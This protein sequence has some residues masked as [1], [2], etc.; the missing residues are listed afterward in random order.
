[1]SIINKAIDAAQLNGEKVFTKSRLSFIRAVAIW[2]L[3]AVFYFYD[4]L[5]QVSPSAMKPEL[6]LA[7]TSHAEQF[8]SLSAYCLYAYGLM[9]IPAGLLLDRFGPKRIIT[10]ACALCA[11]GS[12]IFGLSQTLWMAKL[13]RVCIGAGASFALLCCLKVISLWFPRARYA[14]M[15]GCTVT[16]GYLGGAFGLA[17]VAKVV[18]TVGWRETMYWGAGAGLV[19]CL[20]LWSIV[21]EKSGTQHKTE[22]KTNTATSENITHAINSK[23]FDNKS[24]IG[25][26]QLW[27]DLKYILQNKQTWIAALFAGLMFVPTLAMGGLWGIPFLM[28]AHGFDRDSAGMCASM[29][30]LGW[31]FGSSLWGFLSD[32]F[33][34]R[35]LPMMVGNII[36]FFLSLAI[37]YVDHLSLTSMKTLFFSLGFFSSSFLI[38]FAVVAENN[39][40]KLAATASGFTNALNTLWGALAQPFIGF[41]LDWSSTATNTANEAGATIAAAAEVMP[42]GATE[43]GFTLAQYQQAFLTLPVCLG[44]SFVILFFLKETYCGRRNE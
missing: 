24:N 6:T 19:L 3:V 34:R 40:S 9:Q 8:G 18:E 1:M 39:P 41:I 22:E 2:G 42:A 17:F 35:N 27:I 16:V 23:S 13:G 29:M 36:T 32:H 14:L 30:Y 5:L 11:A 26:S 4:N 10:I 15:T 37:I 28:E 20:L 7:F 33:G 21:S 25:S 31:V 43:A 38:A 12:L 44:I